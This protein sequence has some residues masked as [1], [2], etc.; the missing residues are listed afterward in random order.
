M[1]VENSHDGAW[2]AYLIHFLWHI[3]PTFWHG[4]YDSRT[5][6]FSKDDLRT[7]KTIEEKDQGVVAYLEDF[8]LTPEIVKS[9]LND[10]YYITCCYWSDWGGLIRELVEITIDDNKVVDFF[11]VQEKVEFEYDCGIKF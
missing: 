10:K 2:Q 5:Y 3:L 8:D 7:L 6:L 9:T 4:G 11:N 1:S